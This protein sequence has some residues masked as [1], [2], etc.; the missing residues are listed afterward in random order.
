MYINGKQ[1]S[2]LNH[3]RAGIRNLDT[4]FGQSISTITLLILLLFSAIY[5]TAIGSTNWL[6]VNIIGCTALILAASGQTFVLIT[7]GIDLSIEGVMAL[8]SCLLYIISPKDII[9]LL[10]SVLLI[11]LIGAAIGFING[12]LTS[13]LNLPSYLV[14]FAT[15]FITRGI[16][17]CITAM[18]IALNSYL[19]S[20]IS[21]HQ[22]YIL[23]IIIIIAVILLWLYLKRTYYGLSLFAIEQ[24]QVSA[25]N[26]GI[27]VART[28]ILSYIICGIFAALAGIFISLEEGYASSHISK[29][30]DFLT[31]CAALL[32]GTY[33]I[34]GKGSVLR[35][36][37]GCLALQLFIHLVVSWGI[38]I[39]WA[40]LLRS[41]ICLIMI[42]IQ[43][44]NTIFIKAR[45]KRRT[46][47]EYSIH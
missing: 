41:S 30:Y 24:N 36:I 38:P 17:N 39:Y 47:D 12:F 46:I 37:I 33:I 23:S 9:S 25:Y 18:K 44:Y 2:I 29:S 35:T 42:V 14:T 32:G 8:S 34:R 20:I 6:S 19:S 10:L 21:N 43:I 28:R 27:N 22:G 5:Y 11:G 4:H 3:L 13:K 45:K 1:S 15:L 7:R 16:A 40:K 31:I 26:Y